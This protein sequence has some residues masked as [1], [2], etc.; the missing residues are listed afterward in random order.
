MSPAHS[1]RRLGFTMIEMLIVFVVFAAVVTISIRSVG[2]T[3]RRDRVAKVAAILGAD[4]EQ[5]FALAARQR[6]P[7][8]VKIAPAIR[9]FTIEDRA[10]S[11][12][13]FRTRSFA[14]GDLSLD[15]I[16]TND[17]ILDIMPSGISTDTLKLT[18]GIYTK[19]GAEYTKL[20]RSSIAGLVRVDNR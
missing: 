13:K 9:R 5:A 4:M 7:V 12:V 6:T 19:G 1:R 18:L 16:T 20:V 3:L 17:T 14:T 10:D 8:R 11:T 2:D 15:F